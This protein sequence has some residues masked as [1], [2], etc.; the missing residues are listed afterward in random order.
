MGPGQVS[1]LER[2]LRAGDEAPEPRT[3]Y[4]GYVETG[5][6]LVRPEDDRPVQ[7]MSV[8]KGP[9]IGPGGRWPYTIETDDGVTEPYVS[10]ELVQ[11]IRLDRPYPRTA[12]PRSEHPTGEPTP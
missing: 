10:T 9:V 2:W 7:V 3:I 5:D 6:L 8:R 12:S 11:V 1:A 4:A